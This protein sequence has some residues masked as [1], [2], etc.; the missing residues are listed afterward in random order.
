MV[1]LGFQI[2]DLAGLISGINRARIN[3]CSA[4]V[5]A[6]LFLFGEFVQIAADGLRRYLELVYQL[7]GGDESVLLDQ[8][9]NQILSATLCH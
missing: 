9:H 4:V 3:P 1:F 8:L 7:F 2:H 5:P 6:E